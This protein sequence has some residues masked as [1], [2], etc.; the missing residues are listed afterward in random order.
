VPPQARAP[1][2]IGTP[3]LRPRDLGTP[4]AS[5]PLALLLGSLGDKQLLL[6]LDNCEHLL[7][8]AAQLAAEIIKTAPDVRLIAPSREPLSAPGE[9]VVPVP[10]LELPPAHSTE[11]L[12]QVRQNEAVSLFTDR[13]AAASGAI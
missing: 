2:R 7:G 8:A 5:G 3:V 11:P 10:P 1:A 9:N 4:A 13:A 12:A 6:V